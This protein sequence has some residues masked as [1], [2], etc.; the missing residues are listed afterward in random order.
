MTVRTQHDQIARRVILSITIL[1][2]N[3]KDLWMLIKT[4]LLT[5]FDHASD[6]H[7]LAHS[8]KFWLPNFFLGLVDARSRAKFSLMRRR[9]SKLFR[10][11]LAF[12][13]YRATVMEGA[14]I[15]FARAVLRTIRPRT[16]VFEGSS[17]SLAFGV[18]QCSLGQC[19]ASARTISKTVPPI[20][21]NMNR[22]AAVMAFQHLIRGAQYAS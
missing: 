15:T 21:A 16:D 5:F 18:N 13:N 19:C 2:M 12:I 11:M 9:A 7:R 22:N 4:T 8:G 6:S 20:A 17:A 10:T 1:V 3:A 14:V